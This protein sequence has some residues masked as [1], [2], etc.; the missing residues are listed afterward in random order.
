MRD[1]SGQLKDGLLHRARV[2]RVDVD[3]AALQCLETNEGTAEGEAAIDGEATI[4]QE[5][6]H[7]LGQYLSLDILLATDDDRSFRASGSQVSGPGQQDS[8]DEPG[9]TAHGRPSRLELRLYEVAKELVRRRVDNL[10]PRSMLGDAAAIENDQ[11]LSKPQRFAQ[12]VRNQDHGARLRLLQAQELLLDVVAGDRIEGA[13][14]LVEQEKR[15]LEHHGPAQADTLLLAPGQ[16]VRVAGRDRPRQADAFHH[17]LSAGA[18]ALGIPTHQASQQG[19]VPFDGQVRKEAGPLDSVTDLPPQFW[20][21]IVVD[22]LAENLDR[23]GTGTHET[24]DEL[25]EG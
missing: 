7:D 10:F 5:L 2:F 6:G 19:D 13:E 16:L 1:P 24:V 3:G 23:T 9:A 18:D 21:S 11:P 4:L 22:R 17:P 12:V 15:R 14:R 20:Q 8:Q 25:Q